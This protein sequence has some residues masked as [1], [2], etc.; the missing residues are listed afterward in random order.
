[1]RRNQS[2]K[3]AKVILGATILLVGFSIYMKLE[4]AATGIWATGVPSAVALYMNK[5]YQDRKWGEIESNM[6][7]IENNNA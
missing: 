3:I 4:G 2:K 5:Q 1:M 6:K 7:P